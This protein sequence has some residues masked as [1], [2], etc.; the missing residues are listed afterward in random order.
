MF[1]GYIDILVV[2]ML[3]TI[4]YATHCWGMVILCLW[5]NSG[6]LWIGATLVLRQKR[7]QYL[8]ILSKDHAKTNDIFMDFIEIV[9]TMLLLEFYSM[10]QNDIT[11]Q[12]FINIDIGIDTDV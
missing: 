1:G 3:T 12:P 7:V 10:I 11:L 8:F 5:R 2:S 9:L 4:D 6:Q